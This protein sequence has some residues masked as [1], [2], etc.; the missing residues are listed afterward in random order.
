M[1]P[2]PPSMSLIETFAQLAPSVRSTEDVATTGRRLCDA[3]LD[4]VTNC[5]AASVHV[6]DRSGHSTRVETSALA[7]AA[8]QVMAE[9]TD[10]VLVAP[11][12]RENWVHVRDLAAETRWPTLAQRLVS[13]LGV[14]SLISCRMTVDA[15][16]RRPLGTLTVY[17]L[18][19]GA[20]AEHDVMMAVL[21]SSLG[22]VVLDASQQPAH[23]REAIQTRQVIGEAIGVLR[24]QT[25]VS[26]DEAFRR[27]SSASQRTNIKL[28]DLAVWIIDGPEPSEDGMIIPLRREGSR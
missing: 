12:S 18:T 26:S 8:D 17:S 13:Q 27:L 5:D 20:F 25:G 16:P 19:P 2:A 14:G 24:A 22:G 1:T 28:R 4:V 23:L 15:G 6:R 3:V 11:S 21:L 10:G 7:T 9:E